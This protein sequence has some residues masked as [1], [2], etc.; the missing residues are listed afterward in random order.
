MATGCARG[1]DRE[2]P[3]TVAEAAGAVTA[4]ARASTAVGPASDRARP[5]TA[6]AGGRR[7]PAAATAPD[8]V[9]GRSIAGRPPRSGLDPAARGARGLRVLIGSVF[10]YAAASS[11]TARSTRLQPIMR[12]PRR[13]STGSLSRLR[14]HRQHAGRGDAADLRRPRGRARLQGRPLQHR[15]PGPAPDGRPRRGRGRRRAGRPADLARGPAR[16]HRRHARR[17][18][19]GASSPA[20]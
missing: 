9:R 7:L 16:V 14:P 11:R 17:G 1:G 4:E 3:T 8:R 10:V 13:C 20:R 15:R 5:P 19:S 18:A 2:R 6:D 12:L